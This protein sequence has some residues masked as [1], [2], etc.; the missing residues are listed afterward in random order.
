M[1][2]VWVG[3]V[4]PEL[5]EALVSQ[6]YQFRQ[7]LWKLTVQTVSQIIF[8]EGGG[9]ACWLVWSESPWLR[10]WDR[11]HLSDSHKLH[12]GKDGCFAREEITRYTACLV[13]SLRWIPS[14]E[15]GVWTGSMKDHKLQAD[16]AVPL[17]RGRWENQHRVTCISTT[18]RLRE[19]A[20][21][22]T[23]G[24]ANAVFLC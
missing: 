17:S 11:Q 4:P 19:F 1:D 9:S 20:F 8:D 14:V 7:S 24:V 15:G 23:K 12:S 3:A 22:W 5:S 2:Q 6:P 16:R 10:S 18:P 13:C 21:E